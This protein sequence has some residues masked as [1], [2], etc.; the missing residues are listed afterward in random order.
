M[1]IVGFETFPVS[2]PYRHTELSSRVRRDGVSD[3]VV[4]LTADDGS[5]GWGESCS[6]ADIASIESA[7]L[8]MSAYVVG[9]SPWEIEQT[10]ADVYTKGLWDYRGA[11][12]HFAFAGIDM[13]LWD[14]CGK[15]SGQPLY[16]LLGG[17]CRDEVD[18]FY[19]LS[20]ADPDALASECADGV[21]RGY[22]CFYLKVGVD[23]SAEEAKLATIRSAIG[24]SRRIR[25][26]ANEAWSLPEAARW[27]TT[28][29]QRF[30]IDFA[31]APV[32]A[33][34]R[35]LM[36]KLRRLVPVRLCA[37]EGLGS[38]HDVLDTIAAGASD[39]L[40]FSSYWVGTL[41]RF[42]SL[43]RIA[44]RHGIEVCKHT[45]G[46]LG[47]AAAAAH[48]AMLTLP[49]TCEGCQQ[50]SAILADDIL[51]EDLPI[52]HGPRWGMIEG[53]GLGIEIDEEKLR[54]YADAHRRE[55]QFL[56]YGKTFSL[57]QA[58]HA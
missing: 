6:G 22:S 25:I 56:P 20:G 36:Q 58:A 35:T 55:G 43:A 8:A 53:P 34:P 39:V 40:C 28:W 29:H 16:R 52:A 7:L 37:N 13:A 18:Y 24:P 1:K 47:I 5:V 26:D 3:V 11:T 49:N 46:E 38:E 32:K 15:D 17:A 4:K 30:T 10:A 41:K 45:H 44:S 21:A 31:E 9:R 51:T 2:I 48:H 19:Y 33:V 42:Q 50:T 54:K 12:A 14:L 27:L 57:L 23:A